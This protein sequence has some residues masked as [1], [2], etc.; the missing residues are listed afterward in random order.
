MIPRR[1]LPASLQ[2]T[3]DIAPADFDRFFDNYMESN[4]KT[5]AHD[6]TLTLGGS[7]VFGCIRKAWYSRHGTVKDADYEDSWGATERGN[8]IENH[9][10]VPAM[11]HASKNEGF[12]IDYVGG[13][14]QT[15]FCDG[16]PMS[17]TPDGLIHG[18]P[19]NWLAK[20]GIKDIKADCVMFEIKSI[21][22]RVDLSE[23]KAIHHGQTQIQMG[24]VRENTRFRPHYAVIL[25]VNASFFDDMKVYIVEWDEDKYAAA[26]AR[27][28]LVYECEDPGTLMREGLLDNSCRYCPFQSTCI[29]T[30][31]AAMPPKKEEGKGKK[32]RESDPALVSELEAVMAKAHEIRTKKKKIEK[33]DATV[34]EQIKQVLRDHGER[35]AN[36]SNWRVS[37]SM[38]DGRESFDKEKLSSALEM[39]TELMIAHNLT[40]E[41]QEVLKEAGVGEE[42]QNEPR[43]L[44][45]ASFTKRGDPFEVLRLTYTEPDSEEI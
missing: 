12:A 20:Y 1:R 4:K 31:V 2:K 29:Q 27:S 13:D 15:L 17:V 8:L 32:K 41:L 36:D 6:R 22:P 5:W 23:E 21:D 3:I 9:H 28:K 19:R 7:E 10:V 26:K 16:I 33:E 43:M 42:G 14:Q 34:K 24:L 11:L 39:L 30:T 35:W 38:S 37:Y 18:I 45:I 44:D 40:D 25:Y